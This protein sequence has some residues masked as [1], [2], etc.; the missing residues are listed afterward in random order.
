[1]PPNDSSAAPIS[2]RAIK[3]RA[4]QACHHCRTRKVKCDLV[5]SGIPCHN[6]ESDGVECLVVE[7]RR[8]RKYRLQKRQLTGLVSLPPLVQAQPRSASEGSPS[9]AGNEEEPTKDA[10]TQFNLG[11]CICDDVMRNG[12][13]NV[14]LKML[15]QLLR[16]L[17]ASFTVL[18]PS[19]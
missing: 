11:M 10:A 6:C 16:W 19:P 9:I 5:K 12:E 2:N 7:S 1:M 13:A 18:L 15:R 3:K 8:S 17:A 14:W 4:S